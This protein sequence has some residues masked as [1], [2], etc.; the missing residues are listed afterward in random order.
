MLNDVFLDLVKADFL[1]AID[2][3]AKKAGV[4]NE[5]IQ[6]RIKLDAEEGLIYAI[7]H[8]WKIANPKCTFKEVMC[9]QLDVFN[10]EG[11]LSPHIHAMLLKQLSNY[12]TDT[13]NFSAFLF[14]RNKTIGC[15]LYVGS[16]PVKV[17]LLSDLFT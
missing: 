2:K 4:G 11:M 10:K 9:I 5:D 3:H 17:C 16:Q 13:D 7:F 14:Q 6:I 1:K 12:D 15:A 8:E